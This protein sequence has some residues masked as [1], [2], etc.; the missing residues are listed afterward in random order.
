[1]STNYSTNY[2]AKFLE[3]HGDDDIKKKWADSLPEF[4]KILKKDEK[5]ESK[6]NKTYKKAKTAYNIFCSDVRELVKKEKPD[7]NNKEIFGEMALRWKS[8]NPTELKK[9]QALAEE[10]KKRY[11]NDKETN[12]PVST[13]KKSSSK[14]AK[15]A[16]MF[17]C[18]DERKNIK[19][20]KG[21]EILVELGAR[22]KNLKNN[23]SK[24]VKVYE[25]MAEKDRARLKGDSE[26]KDFVEEEVVEEE[27]EEVVPEPVPEVKKEVVKK[28][29]GKA[30]KK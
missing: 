2:F 17:F 11:L 4:K 30:S 18:D 25:D 13:D 7:L 24:K 6:K 8:I 12:E 19:D 21:K 28:T 14:R 3:T 26:T 15:S 29:K 1:M 16:Y 22:W 27:E 20:L 5:K 23:D 9:Y 10:D